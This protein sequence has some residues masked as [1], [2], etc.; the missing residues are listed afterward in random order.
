MIEGIN[1]QAFMGMLRSTRES[2]QMND[3]EKSTFQAILEKYDASSM[4]KEDKKSMFEEIRETGIRPNR[5]M[6]EMLESA[7]FEPPAR[8]QGPPP[9]DPSTPG[10]SG[11][12]P[13]FLQD[14]IS[15]FREGTATETDLN[16]LLEQLM[17]NGLSASGNIIDENS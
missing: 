5:E 1:N 8:P 13:D 3:D 12:M 9:Q 16:Q 2:Y 17:Q 15:K 10:R 6:K 7:G 14:F 4:S 11:E